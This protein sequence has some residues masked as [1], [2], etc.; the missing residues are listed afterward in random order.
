MKSDKELLKIWRE[1]EETRRHSVEAEV[2]FEDLESDE[3][4]RIFDLIKLGQHLD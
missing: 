1:V 2:K 4:L 3:K